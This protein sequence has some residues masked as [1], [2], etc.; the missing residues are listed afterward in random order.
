MSLVSQSPL[1]PLAFLERSARV[2]TDK[3]AIVDGDREIGYP[4]FGDLAQRLGR[5]LA[6]RASSP[7]PGG[8]GAAAQ[9][10]RD[11]GRALRRSSLAGAA[12]AAINTRLAAE[13]IGY[14]LAHSGARV[15][16]VD[17]RFEETVRGALAV[18][19]DCE[20]EVVFTRS[21]AAGFGRWDNLLAAGTA[22][23]PLPWAV[24][25]ELSPLAINYTSGT[26]GRPK[27]P[28]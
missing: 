27:G 11:A 12:I 4:E 24:A 25:D 10:P 18:L 3:V 23:E 16:L 21:G 9:L 5:G 2:W 28:R 17:P 22:G 19:D 7:G 20:L 14:I 15:L 1:T 8:G 26:T 6:P 13:E